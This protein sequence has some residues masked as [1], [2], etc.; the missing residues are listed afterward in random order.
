MARRE[1]A[2]EIKQR[3]VAQ[4]QE[5]RLAL[6]MEAEKAREQYSPAA[7]AS[8]SLQKHKIAWI[9][10]GAVAGL[11]AIRLLLPSKNNRSDI[12]G[13]TA[14]K[15]GFSGVL[16]GIAKTFVQRAALNYAKD[17][18]QAHFKDSLNSLFERPPG[19]RP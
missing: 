3:L 19:P 16:S 18:L 10:G 9:V 2:A 15:R 5:S 13:K 6:S 4:L 7:L 12:S 1:T 11:V 17:H 8:R 14:T